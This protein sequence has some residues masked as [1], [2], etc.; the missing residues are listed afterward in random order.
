MVG[1]YKSSCQDKSLY[2]CAVYLPPRPTSV[3]VQHTDKSQISESYYKS[4]HP[5]PQAKVCYSYSHP[6]KLISRV[7]EER[8]FDLKASL[9]S[10]F[11]QETPDLLKNQCLYDFDLTKLHKFVKDKNDFH[12][13]QNVLLKHFSKI[14]TI[15][16][17]ACSRAASYPSVNWC[18]FN[19]Y[20]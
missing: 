11:V 18:D 16:L 20:C 13:V 2:V 6:M 7:E 12:H 14:K 1:A 5:G 19:S 9:F 4:C 15:F 17:T 10:S 8:P 3:I